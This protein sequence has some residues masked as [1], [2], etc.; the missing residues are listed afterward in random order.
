[1]PQFGGRITAPELSDAFAVALTDLG[2]APA[3][4]LKPPMFPADCAC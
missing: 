2:R 3:T 4:G 1:M